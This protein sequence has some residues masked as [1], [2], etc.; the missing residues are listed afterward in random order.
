MD[1]KDLL[2][3]VKHTYVIIDGPDGSGKNLQADLLARYWAKHNPLLFNDPDTTHPPGQLLR[4]FLSSGEYPTTH[5]LLS[6]ASQLATIE[7]RIVP[8]LR[9]ERPVISV[10]GFP[11]TLV[12]QQEQWDFSWLFS[13]L[14]KIRLMLMVILLLLT[15]V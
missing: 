11:S 12:Y 1:H 3:G 13:L 14:Q 9:E 15:E 2:S 5:A 8:A 10:R 7:S 4:R 6:V